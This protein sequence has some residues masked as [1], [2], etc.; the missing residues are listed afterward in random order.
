[1]TKKE[2]VLSLNNLPSIVE[3]RSKRL[4]QGHG[5]GKVKTAGRGT[6]GQKAR[7][8]IPLLFAGSSLQASWLKRLPLLRGKGKNKAINN[9]KPV[10]INVKFLN[11]LKANSEVTLESLKKAGVVDQDETKVK[12]LGDGDLNVALTVKLPVSSGA[13]AKIE[14]AGGKVE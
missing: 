5:S 6:K 9:K 14:K 3:R 7:G 4:G 12:I 11:G 13:K 1:M 2:D 10:I 8:K